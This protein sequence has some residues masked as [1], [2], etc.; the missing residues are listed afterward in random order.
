MGSKIV[1]PSGLIHMRDALVQLG[2]Y[3]P[4]TC[5][6]VERQVNAGKKMGL[7]VAAYRP[8][9]DRAVIVFTYESDLRKALK[10]MEKTVE[11]I[12]KRDASPDVGREMHASQV[13]VDELDQ[14]LDQLDTT[15]VIDVVSAKLDELATQLAKVQQQL[16]ALCRAW[17]INA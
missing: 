8:L 11:H 2:H 13:E 16:A 6:G 14:H 15:G 1:P 4:K 3:G 9:G 12:E 7:R 10:R 17:D 5:A